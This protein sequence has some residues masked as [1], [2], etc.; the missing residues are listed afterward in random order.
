M[1]KVIYFLVVTLMIVS[2]AYA[3]GKMKITAKDL[4][5]LKGSWEGMLGWGLMDVVDSPVK[6]EI[7][8]DA[9]PVKAKLTISNVPN[10]VA[11]QFGW[12]TGNHV[13]DSDEGLL[14]T[15][16]TLMWTG[17]NKNWLELSAGDKRLTGSYYYRGVKGDISLRKK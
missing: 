4:P 12:M 15:Q 11:S 9:V 8:N 7:L 6:L 13:V 17:S 3:A 10:Q 14:T 5:G 16:G 1:R 2:V